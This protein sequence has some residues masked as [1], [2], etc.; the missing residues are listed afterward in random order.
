MK[1]QFSNQQLAIAHVETGN[2]PEAVMNYLEVLNWY[3]NGGA[4]RN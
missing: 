4:Y 2:I 1:L 3:L